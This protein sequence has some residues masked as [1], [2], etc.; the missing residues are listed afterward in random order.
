MGDKMKVSLLGSFEIEYNG[1]KLLYHDYRSKQITKLLT[2]LILNRKK[3]IFNTT[4]ADIM[5]NDHDSNDPINALK[6]LVYRVR[7]VLK[8]S[9]GDEQ[10]IL[11]AKGSYYWNPNIEVLV[12]AEEFIDT[13]KCEK[14]A[15]KQDVH[16]F[17]EKA[18]ALY[19]GR[20]LPMLAGDDWIDSE[21]QYLE[22][23]ALSVMLSL[24][25]YYYENK[26]D[27]KFEEIYKKFLKID[28]YNESVYYYGISHYMDEGH[29]DIARK[30]YA[31]IE[32]LFA[33]NLGIKPSEKLTKLLD[34][35]KKDAGFCVY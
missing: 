29:E 6:A 14:F 10:F 7:C 16:T 26:I 33:K 23:Q 21:N 1:E 24:I 19:K 20:M 2:Y 18:S 30:Y 4:T 11:N 12:D 15:D 13:L 3:Q 31:Q 34:A 9:F 28:P 32:K 8:K 17:Y 25:K 27:N 22:T 35:K 5:F